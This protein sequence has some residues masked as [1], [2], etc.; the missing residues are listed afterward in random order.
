ML[1]IYEWLKLKPRRVDNL[2]QD[3]SLAGL[4]AA[5]KARYAA[6]FVEQLK[7]FLIFHPA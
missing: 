5:T 3:R 4:F 7:F 1:R 6:D 2:K